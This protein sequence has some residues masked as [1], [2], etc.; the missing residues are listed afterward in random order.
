MD[1][2]PAVEIALAKAWAFARQVD[3][4]S[5]RPIDLLRGLFEE[6]ESAAMTHLQAAGLTLVS[7]RHF[8]PV[9]IGFDGSEDRAPLHHETRTVL[10][11]ALEL[12]RLHGAEESITSEF[13]LLALLIHDKPIRGQ[14]ESYGLDPAK[15]QARIAPPPTQP[16]IALEEP[17]DL[18]PPRETMDLARLLDAAANRAR[19]ALRVLEDHTR[20]TLN[21]A[22]LSRQLKEMRHRLA[23]ALQTL[24]AELLLSARNTP[25]D[26]GVALATPQEQGRASPAA[27]VAANAKRLQEALRSL[28]EYGK[29]FAPDLGQAIE[30]LRYEAYTL[31]KALVLGAD[32]RARLADAKLY[33]LV[34]EELCR[35]SL[36]G[37][38][39]EA[40]AGGA[41]VIQLREKKLTDRRLLDLARDLRRMTRQAGALLMINDR[42]DIAALAEADGVHLGQDDLSVQETRSIVGSQMLIGV[43]TH[44]LEQVRRAVLDGA[45]YIGIGPTFPSKTKAFDELAGLEFIRQASAETTLPAFALGGITLENIDQVLA[46]G[47]RRVAVSSAICGAEDPKNAAAKL[48]DALDSYPSRAR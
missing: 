17:L 22:Y 7:V 39:R 40:L 44:N 35:A 48:R 33:V 45:S 38:V 36:V 32:T 47:A 37:T 31:E 9:L 46:A 12:T 6:E 3:Q 10:D 24:P 21:D 41:Q 8:F 18:S 13:V 30:K 43:S 27:V 5:V 20:F 34:T 28:E 11:T 23:D 14:L 26:V 19:E 15:L 25:G 2:S 4:P 1:L 16:P 29:V 42:P